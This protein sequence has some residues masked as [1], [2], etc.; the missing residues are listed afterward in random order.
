MAQTIAYFDRFGLSRQY[1]SI[2][3]VTD[4]QENWTPLQTITATAECSKTLVTC[5]FLPVDFRGWLVLLKDGAKTMACLLG[6]GHGKQYKMNLHSQQWYCREHWIAY[7]TSSASD[8]VNA[9][10]IEKILHTGDKAS[11]NQCK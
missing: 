6:K 2:R 7:N 8:I 9:T 11:L 5:L 4:C 10:N 1:Q 3:T